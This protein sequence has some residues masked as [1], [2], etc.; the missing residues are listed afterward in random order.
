MKILSLTVAMVL[1]LLGPVWG[2]ASKPKTLDELVAYTGADRQKLILDGAK[3]EGKV[4]WYTSLSGNYREIVDAF[5]KKYPEV[6]IEVYR[7]GSSDVAERLLNEAKAGRYLAD[8][9]ETT[10]GSLMLLRD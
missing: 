4:V 8:A 2:Q 9:M 10:P 3:A 5:K 6:Q 7:A 1:I